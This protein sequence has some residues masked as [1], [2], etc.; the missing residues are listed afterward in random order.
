[1]DLYHLPGTAND[2]WGT[3]IEKKNGKANNGED[4]ECWLLKLGGSKSE[5]CM[6]CITLEFFSQ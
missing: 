2:H 1:M 3:E 6:E 4:I 5:P